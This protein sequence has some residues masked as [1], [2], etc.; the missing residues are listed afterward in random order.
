[1]DNYPLVASAFLELFYPEQFSAFLAEQYLALCHDIGQTDLFRYFLHT[2]QSDTIDE[3]FWKTL[4]KSY[5]LDNNLLNLV[6]YLARR[7]RL[8]TLKNVLEALIRKAE[9]RGDFM[10]CTITT[11]HQPNEEQ[12]AQLLAFLSKK[13]NA[14]LISRF[15][16]DDSLICGMKLRSPFLVAEHSIARFLRKSKI[17]LTAA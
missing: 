1:M 6:S 15:V 16:V 12:Q 8:F 7:K 4:I 14:P 17:D 10:R 3:A 9:Q 5:K 13:C 2:Q 11:S